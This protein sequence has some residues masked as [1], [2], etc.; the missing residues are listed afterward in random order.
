MEMRTHCQNLLEVMEEGGNKD[1]GYIGTH[2]S[3]WNLEFL[4]FT[5]LQESAIDSGDS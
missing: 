1:R 4:V 3:S 5:V 2:L